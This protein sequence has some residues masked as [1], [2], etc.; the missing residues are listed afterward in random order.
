M[1]PTFDCLTAD[2]ICGA[3]T[4]EGGAVGRASFGFDVTPDDVQ[5]IAAIIG[6][7]EPLEPIQAFGAGGEPNDLCGQAK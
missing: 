3:E 6:S 2:A 1:P 7:D 4:D 5:F